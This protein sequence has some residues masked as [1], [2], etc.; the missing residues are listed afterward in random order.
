MIYLTLEV[1]F[2]ERE[3]DQDGKST[4]SSQQG[5]PSVQK[6]KFVFSQPLYGLFDDS[7]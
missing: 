4:G 5:V 3:V 6:C 7:G 1:N 2:Q